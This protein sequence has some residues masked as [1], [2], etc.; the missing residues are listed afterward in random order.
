VAQRYPRINDISTDRE[1]PPAYLVSP[2]RKPDYRAERLREPTERAYGDLENLVL[3][4]PAPQVFAAA[5]A[6]ATQ[7]GWS[8]AARAEGDSGTPWRLQAVDITPRLRF[9]DDVII[10]VRPRGEGACAV[11]MRSK[12]RLGISDFGTNARRI[13]AFFAD[14][15]M[16]LGR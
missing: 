15:R 6:L 5:E 4:Q 12:S 10:E 1:T 16:R 9:K 11:A 7:R 2:P 3:A 14:L 13:R 8:L